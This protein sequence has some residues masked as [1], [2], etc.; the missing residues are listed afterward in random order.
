[1]QRKLKFMPSSID[2]R[3]LNYARHPVV[4]VGTSLVDVFHKCIELDSEHALV[5]DEDGTLFGVV[6]LD[7]IGDLIRSRDCGT[8]WFDRPVESAVM[9]S[10][11]SQT[12]KPQQANDENIRKAPTECLSVFEDG[13]LVAVMTED[14]SLMSWNRIEQAVS[15]AAT[16][17]VTL[18]PNRA[19]F[20]RRLCEEWE[21]AQ[22]LGTTIGVA[23]IDVD[24]FKEINDRFGHSEG[25]RVLK[26]IADCCR[27]QLRSYDLLARHGGDEFA[28]IFCAQT[29]EELDVPIARLL[30][31]VNE[32][33]VK[34]DSGVRLSLSIGTAVTCPSADHCSKEQLIEAADACLYESKNKGRNQTHL[35]AFANGRPTEFRQVVAHKETD[36][37]C[38]LEVPPLR[39][40]ARRG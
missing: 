17:P 36:A 1:M 18:L 24:Y 23:M 26:S 38:G 4:N 34:A 37:S 20:D 40:V 16:D 8:T 27:E 13:S 5:V 35:T 14:D 32:L 19:H 10:L 3:P 2:S 30:S 29:P 11:N 22:Q 25:D 33:T 39:V 9:L 7:T 21:R 12:G 31:A 28:A 6:T 15:H